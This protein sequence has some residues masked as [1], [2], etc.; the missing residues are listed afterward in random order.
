MKEHLAFRR[1]L[2]TEASLREER[3]TASSL[4]KPTAMLNAKHY[5]TKGQEALQSPDVWG[6]LTG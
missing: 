1:L 3:V 5:A 4:R 2:A 6:R